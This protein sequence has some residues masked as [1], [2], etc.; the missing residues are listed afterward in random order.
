V[1]GQVVMVLKNSRYLKDGI[2]TPLV[3]GKIQLQ[4]EA[5]EIFYKD[6]AIKE[7]STL[8]TTYAKFF[9]D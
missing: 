5:A 7:L 4:S 9:V 2:S 1:N 8:A 6:I 3:E